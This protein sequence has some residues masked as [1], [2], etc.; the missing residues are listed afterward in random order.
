MFDVD[1]FD[2]GSDAFNLMQDVIKTYTYAFETEYPQLNLFR[3]GSKLL[4]DFLLFDL[5][6]S[7]F[8]VF[9]QVIDMFYPTRETDK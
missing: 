4:N 1:L 8:E 6:K 3:R 7:L 5:S 9:Y 2:L